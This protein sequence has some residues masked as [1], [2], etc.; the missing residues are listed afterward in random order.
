LNNPNRVRLPLADDLPNSIET[1]LAL[2]LQCLRQKP[3]ISFARQG[4]QAQFV[5]AQRNMQD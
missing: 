5:F 1:T 3:T 4:R 2:S